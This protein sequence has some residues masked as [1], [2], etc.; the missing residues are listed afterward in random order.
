ML[1]KQLGKPPYRAI[2]LFQI[3]LKFIKQVL[4]NFTSPDKLK[5]DFHLYDS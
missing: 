4:L 2:S 5:C 3:G 1:E